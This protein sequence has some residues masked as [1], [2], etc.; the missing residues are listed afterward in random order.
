MI[1]LFLGFSKRR[2][3][4]ALMDANANIH[5]KV[6]AEYNITFLDQMIS[7]ATACT[8]ISY[9]LYTIADETFARF[10]TRNLVFTI[11]F[12]IYGIYRYLYLMH[13]KGKGGDPTGLVLT[14]YPLL[15]SAVGWLGA[16]I[17]IL[18]CAR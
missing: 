14:D 8:V 10:G 16:V 2:H 12:I 7:V 13:W 18:Y 3:E 15:L 6:L 9:S 17:F 1:S 11:P 5:R 4:L